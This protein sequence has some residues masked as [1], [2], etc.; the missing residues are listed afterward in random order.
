MFDDVQHALQLTEDESSML[1]H[2]ASTTTVTA[3]TTANTTV[4]QQLSVNVQ[5]ENNINKTKNDTRMIDILR[6]IRER[7]RYWSVENSN[8]KHQNQ[9]TNIHCNISL[10]LII[11]Y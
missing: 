1:W 5:G 3:A 8:I 11:L 7:V 9:H 6:Q 4:Q 2:N 10:I